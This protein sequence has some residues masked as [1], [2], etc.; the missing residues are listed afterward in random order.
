MRMSVAYFAIA[1]SIAVGIP[2]SANAQ[3]ASGDVVIIGYNATTPDEFR[4]AV[5]GTVGAGNAVNF[6]DRGWLNTGGF[7]SGEGTLIYT[8][9]AGGITAGTAVNWQ[10]NQSVNGTGWSASAPTGFSFDTAGDS[11]IA[12][13]GSA[14]T[15]TLI[16][17][18]RQGSAWDANAINSN[19]SAEPTSTNSGTLTSGVTT[20]AFGSVN[21]YYS[22]PLTSGTRTLLQVAISNPTNWT[23]STSNIA[24]TNWKNS[25]SVG[26]SASLFWDANA[27]TAGT[28]GT[29][30]WDASSNNL[31]SSSSNGTRFRWVNSSSGNDHTAVFAGI[32]GTVSVASSGVTASGLQFD[33]DG[34][35]IQNNAIALSGSTTPTIAVTT[36]GHTATISS[37]LSGTNGLAKSGAGTLVFAGNNGYSGG[38]TI[39][40]GALYANNT[41]GSAT[42]TGA[43]AVNAGTLAG[44]GSVSG[45][46]TINS[47]GTLQGGT[48]GSTAANKLTLTGA[49][50]NGGTLR[51]IVGDASVGI[52]P[53]DDRASL[54]HLTGALT[55]GTGTNA[56]SL[57]NDGTLNFGQS[58]TLTIADFTST[59]FAPG[60]NTGEFTVVA[61]NFTLQSSSYVVTASTLTVTFVPA[62]VP[63]PSTVFGIAVLGLGLIGGVA[64]GRR[65]FGRTLS[66]E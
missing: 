30:T 45:A 43:L 1:I 36:A 2:Q 15:P 24:S 35:T 28:G 37:Q 34:Y 58:Y 6:T 60:T 17:A 50:L 52:N 12:Y 20:I 51:T 13:T 54:L 57:F 14:A 38:T 33:V 48:G 59:S 49:T 42:G 63:E 55:K 9:Q 56:I 7:S 22:A 11:L 29:G 5:L 19:T 46:T 39:N 16:Y 64:R 40:G 44:T 27:T 53:L 32:A 21:G 4:I 62:P 65:Y 10:N 61:E 23:T 3:F 31:F 41:A 66:G 18:L 8:V 47:G 25:F 26:A